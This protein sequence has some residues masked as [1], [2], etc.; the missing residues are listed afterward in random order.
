MWTTGVKNPHACPHGDCNDILTLS[1]LSTNPQALLRLLRNCTSTYIRSY[2][3]TN[4]G[5]GM[6]KW[7][8]MT[9][10]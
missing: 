6:N 3:S 1:G 2:S 5:I 10:Y 4:L 9:Y 7:K 8:I